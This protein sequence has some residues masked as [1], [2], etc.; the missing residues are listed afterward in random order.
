VGARVTLD[1]Q[2]FDAFDSG[3]ARFDLDQ[4]SARRHRVVRLVAL[5]RVGGGVVVVRSVLVR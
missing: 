4:R 3:V 1:G 5:L 2:L